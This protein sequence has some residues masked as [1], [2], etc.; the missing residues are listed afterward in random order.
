MDRLNY[1]KEQ[2]AKELKEVFTHEAEPVFTRSP[3]TGR[4]PYDGPGMSQPAF[5]RRK[6]PIF[7]P[8]LNESS[9]ARQANIVGQPRTRCGT[10]E[11]VIR[12]QRNEYQAMFGRSAKD[13]GGAQVEGLAAAV[14]EMARKRASEGIPGETIGALEALRRLRQVA[15]QPTHTDP[16]AQVAERLVERAG[17]SAGS[18][19]AKAPARDS[20]AGLPPGM[21]GTPRIPQASMLPQSARDVSGLRDGLPPATPRSAR[22]GTPC[23]VRDSI[24][25]D[26]LESRDGQNLQH[27]PGAASQSKTPNGETRWE[28]RR[29]AFASEDR[30]ATGA[31]LTGMESPHATEARPSTAASQGGLEVV[32]P[33]TGASQT[34]KET[35][36]STG[37]SQSCREAPPSASGGRPG[38]GG[39][40]HAGKTTTVDAEL[41]VRREEQE[42]LA[43]VT[44]VDESDHAN[45]ELMASLDIPPPSAQRLE[46][47]AYF[48]EGCSPRRLPPISEPVKR[49][50]YKRFIREGPQVMVLETPPISAGGN[51]PIAAPKSKT[52]LPK[53]PALSQKQPASNFY[54]GGKPLFAAKS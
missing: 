21:P 14:S 53:K 2:A 4:R 44:E 15:E 52:Q 8:G 13:T 42:F 10:G 28:A 5:I 35:R 47:R 1:W 18:S 24:A 27:L 46:R 6:T 7:K 19:P 16:L 3:I 33:S 31:S 39:S 45:P 26:R 54:V 51:R 36:P 11:R 48:L 32:R 40:H 49:S 38:T 9:D 22:E 34:C 41:P 50:A 20:D 25:Q 37:A 17:L 29:Q 43:P 23:S 30:P 12:V